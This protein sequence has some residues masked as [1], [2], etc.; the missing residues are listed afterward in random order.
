MSRTFL[1]FFPPGPQKPL[2]FPL[3]EPSVLARLEIA[4]FEVPDGDADQPRHGMPQGLHGPPDDPVAALGNGNPEPL[5]LL[6][7]FLLLDAVDRERA[8]FKLDP[9]NEGLDL[10]PGDPAADL[11]EVGSRDFIARVLDPFGKIA[12]VGQDQE[13]F[14]IVIQPPRGEGR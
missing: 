5:A 11:R 6:V 13:A 12:V 1:R 2:D 3:L 7:V 14:G 10:L 9:V 4:Q 8:V